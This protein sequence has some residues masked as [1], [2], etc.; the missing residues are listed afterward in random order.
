MFTP[1]THIKFSIRS[2]DAQHLWYCRNDTLLWYIALLYD[3][4]VHLKGTGVVHFCSVLNWDILNSVWRIYITTKM[5]SVYYVCS[6][7]CLQYTISSVYV[8][9]TSSLHYNMSSVH[10]FST[11]SLQYNM[12]SVHHLFSTS[13][14]QYTMSSVHHLFSTSSLQ[15][16]IS[17]VHHIF[18][19]S[20]FLC[21][22]VTV[23]IPGASKD[24]E[25]DDRPFIAPTPSAPTTSMSAHPSWTNNDG[26]LYL[27]PTSRD[28]GYSPCFC[29]LR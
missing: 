28:R 25:T 24:D 23:N 3:H 18:S 20:C 17:S 10:L 8:F 9:S 27:R 2:W 1:T 21:V 26:P 4:A 16:T 12:Y 5:F 15:Y 29:S 19:T 7:P 22:S 13:S 14:L 11:S 6:T